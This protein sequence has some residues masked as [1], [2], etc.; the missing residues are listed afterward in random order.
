[1]PRKVEKAVAVDN[2]IEEVCQEPEV[3]Q[4]E[5]EVKQAELAE[6]QKK[7]EGDRVAAL[8]KELEALR[9][10]LAARP[11]VVQVMAD[12]EKVT[13]RFQADVADDNVAVFGPNGMYGQVT[14]KSGTVIVPKNEWSRFYNESVRR[15]IDN[16]WLVVLTGL[17]DEERQLYNCNY[18]QGE[19]LDEAAFARLLDM[20]QELLEVFPGLCQFHQEMVGRAFLKAWRSGDTRAQDRDLIV[21]LNDLSKQ[22]NQN[23]GS[24]DARRKGVFK[25]IIDEMNARDAQE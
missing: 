12:T 19:V 11:Q 24:G 10:E 1:M 15:M 2:V 25:P 23:L 7:E 9:A 3:K 14:G 6:T 5:P 4:Q 8:E 22:A 20:G 18:G 16:R 21:A 17:T 13:L